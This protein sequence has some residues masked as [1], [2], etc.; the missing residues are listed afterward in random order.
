MLMKN[1]SEFSVRPKPRPAGPGV[2]LPAGVSCF[3]F[4]PGFISPGSSEFLLIMLVLILLFG[5]KDAPRILRSIHNALDKMQ[6]AA[7]GIRYKIMYGDFYKDIADEELYD[8]DADYTDV[9]DEES[10]FDPSRS[11]AEPDP[12][13][14]ENPTPREK[15]EA[16]DP[17]A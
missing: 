16:S 8:V 3:M 9:E 14:D 17:P 6:R 12:P 7:A 2:L 11:T 13:E 10:S 15:P 1:H 5:A 4:S